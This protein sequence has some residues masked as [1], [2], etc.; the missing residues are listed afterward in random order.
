MYLQTI[1]TL[2]YIHLF[3]NVSL[4]KKVFL[5]PMKHMTHAILAVPQFGQHVCDEVGENRTSVPIFHHFTLL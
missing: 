2:N 4:L 5:G 3:H 1:Y